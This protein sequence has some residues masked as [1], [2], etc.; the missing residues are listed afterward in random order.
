MKITERKFI[1]FLLSL[2]SFTVLLL[3][4][5]YE[6]LSLATSI[7]IIGGAYMGANVYHAKNVKQKET[8]EGSNT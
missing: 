3:V 8:N 1:A 5:E 6:P 7:T 4:G 2:I